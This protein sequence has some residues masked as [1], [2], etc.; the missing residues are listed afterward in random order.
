MMKKRNKEVLPT[1][2]AWCT[3]LP[4]AASYGDPGKGPHFIRLRPW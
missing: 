3:P 4:I 2:S 1:G